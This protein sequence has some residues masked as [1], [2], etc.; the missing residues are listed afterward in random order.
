MN[1]SGSP[2][3]YETSAPLS[4]DRIIRRE[5]GDGWHEDG[6]NEQVQQAIIKREALLDRIVAEQ[7]DVYEEEKTQMWEDYFGQAA[8]VNRLKNQYGI[9][10]PPPLENTSTEE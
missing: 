4:E 7:H 8:E 10:E 6:M 5:A 3:N 2:E 1:A 9:D